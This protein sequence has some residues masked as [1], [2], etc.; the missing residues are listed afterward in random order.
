MQP[1]DSNAQLTA[2]LLQAMSA[3]LCY[4]KSQQDSD[5]L[6][7]LQGLHLSRSS[8]ARTVSASAVSQRATTAA[9]AAP[10]PHPCCRQHD[11]VT[12]TKRRAPYHQAINRGFGTLNCLKRCS[13][14]AQEPTCRAELPDLI[15]A[16]PL[17][18]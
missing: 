18:N 9:P 5:V 4:L 16:I 10:F 15:H 7:C 13:E 17:N 12:D 6:A 2:N 11:L 1:P 8:A 3:S 14:V